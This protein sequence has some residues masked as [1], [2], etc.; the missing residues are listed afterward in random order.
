MSGKR[1]SIR[2]PL[3]LS[4]FAAVA[5]AAGCT[6][7]GYRP[8]FYDDK[9]EAENKKIDALRSRVVAAEYGLGPDSISALAKR[10]FAVLDSEKRTAFLDKNPLLKVLFSGYSSS[11]LDALPRGASEAD[12]SA[13]RKIIDQN[14]L[15]AGLFNNRL[16]SRWLI[17]RA[18]RIGDVDL[19]AALKDDEDASV[20]DLLF[21]INASH[22]PYDER[23]AFFARNKNSRD[24]QYNASAL[25]YISQVL[26]ADAEVQMLEGNIPQMV[27][28][29]E[30]AR[31]IARALSGH[32]SLKSNKNVVA[33][34][35]LPLSQLPDK[36]PL[37]E[38]YSLDSL[39]ER[40]EK[41]VTSIDEVPVWLAVNVAVA[42]L[43]DSL[44]KHSYSNCHDALQGAGMAI[45][46]VP[47]A[48]PGLDDMDRVVAK[49]FVSEKIADAYRATRTPGV[50]GKINWLDLA[51]L[52]LP[53]FGPVYAVASGAVREAL[54][55]DEFT[56]KGSDN[57]D[58]LAK[59]VQEGSRRS[60]GDGN[61][62]N[63]VGVNLT[64]RIGIPIGI[65]TTSAAVAGAF[66]ASAGGGGAGAAVGAPPIGGGGGPPVP[67]F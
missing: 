54:T 37:R 5:I 28:N 33:A 7:P 55:P 43:T 63:Y 30:R 45:L 38:R 62:D 56:P 1:Y 17:L 46:A 23:R 15:I 8:N 22:V 52:S 31:N 29:Y 25:S 66:A 47:L 59:L 12:K 16:L 32:D 35:N 24:A 13:L 6:A 19:G 49:H 41:P 53:V 4:G 3:A 48:L 50:A 40:L 60:W 2:V 67:P 10:E 65:I 39:N 20:S 18:S 11:G 42:E 26:S 36:H 58:L 14:K 9:F 21:K 27:T 64:P 34:L 51:L 44:A 57:A 61:A